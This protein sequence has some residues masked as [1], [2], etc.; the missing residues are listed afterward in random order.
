[1]A[2]GQQYLTSF[3]HFTFNGVP[4]A[5]E[6]H[7]QSPTADQTGFERTCPTCTSTPQPDGSTVVTRQE[8]PGQGNNR[9]MKIVSAVHFRKDGSVVRIST[10]NYD[11]TSPQQPVYQ[12]AVALEVAQLTALAT[13]TAFHL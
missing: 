6:V 11:P 7:V 10:Y 5:V 2:D 3:V 8:D 4:T 12:K 9:E 13:D 1:L